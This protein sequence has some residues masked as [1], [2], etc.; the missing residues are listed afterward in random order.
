[1]KWN[2]RWSSSNAIAINY[3]Q[4]I[5]L[6]CLS[7]FRFLFLFYVNF[8]F[9]HSSLLLCLFISLCL[10][11]CKPF[12]TTIFEIY[13]C[14][15]FVRFR[16]TLTDTCKLS[17]KKRRKLTLINRF[18]FVNKPNVVCLDASLPSGTISF[19]L[20]KQFRKWARLK[21][22]ESWKIK[23]MNKMIV[24]EKLWFCG[25]FIVDLLRNKKMVRSE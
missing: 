3:L 18:A 25:K 21:I 16:E 17:K 9:S 19:N 12:S 22:E 20:S 1:M 15:F 2:E 4:T 8:P 7:I 10:C 5:L 6:H 24:K 11:V 23:R 14:F 13:L